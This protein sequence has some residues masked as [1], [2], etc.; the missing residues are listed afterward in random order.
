MSSVDRVVR[1]AADREADLVG[2]VRRRPWSMITRVPCCQLHAER[3]GDA[4]NLRLAFRLE[5]LHDRDR[6]AV[7]EAAVFGD[8]ADLLGRWYPGPCRRLSSR[9]NT[10]AAAAAVPA[11]AAAAGGL[12]LRCGCG[13]GW[14]GRRGLARRLGGRLG[15]RLR[16]RAMA[17]SAAKEAAAAAVS[18]RPTVPRRCDPIIHCIRPFSQPFAG[19]IGRRERSPLVGLS[20]R[21]I[22][23]ERDPRFPA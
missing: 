18:T 19:P 21:Q 20:P 7:L 9:A 6:H 1:H 13:C 3:H 11:P 12:R 4:Q 2:R 14:L 16:Q 17:P 23:R 8:D 5:Q 22:R 15:R 10:S